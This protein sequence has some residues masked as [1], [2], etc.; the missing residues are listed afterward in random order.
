MSMTSFQRVMAAIALKEPDRVPIIP[1]ARAFIMKYG[2]FK[3]SEC[4]GE[5]DKYIRAQMQ[6]IRDF[7]FDAVT[8]MYCG[9]P[10]INEFLGGSLILE[11]GGM[12]SAR[13][14]FTSAEEFK[15]KARLVDLSTIKRVQDVHRMI[16]KL[17]EEVRGDLPVIAY[18]HYPFRTAALLRGIQDFFMDMVI[19][20][21]FIRDLLDFC[22]QIC[23]SYA[24]ILI[25]AGTDIIFTSQA[26]ANRDCISRRH[27]EEFVFGH[28]KELNGFLKS[29]SKPILHHTCGD[30]S[31]RFDL[32][33]A[34]GPEVAYVSAK[35]D[36][37]H[38][39]AQYGDRICIM[40]NLHAVDVVAKGTTEEIDRNVAECIARAARGGGY[41]LSG[42]CDVTYDTPTENIRALEKAGKRY[43]VYPLTL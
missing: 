34:E 37:S 9:V 18:A 1:M 39:K 31:D 7:G 6:V 21:S 33:M 22:L 32:V 41:I 20:P 35:F 36:M 27:Y 15:S 24:E 40:G 13:P 29:K 38:L 30:W 4:F 19:N 5:P 28:E 3:I 2:G 25:D 43:G 10:L 12:P 11:N 23:K 16:R 26:V 17:K 14:V 8:E 42:D